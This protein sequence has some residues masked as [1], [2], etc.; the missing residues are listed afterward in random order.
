MLNASKCLYLKRKKM[1]VVQIDEGGRYEVAAT[2]EN[3]FAFF[4]HFFPSLSFRA[5]EN[6]RARCELLLE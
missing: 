2:L 1:Q 4:E 3:T 5:A 6:D